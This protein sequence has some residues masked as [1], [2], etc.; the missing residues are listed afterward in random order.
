MPH[1]ETK[2]ADLAA[3][4][5]DLAQDLDGA[6]I[7]LQLKQPADASGSVV[8]IVRVRDTTGDLGST[9][10]CL[11]RCLR[12]P[13]KTDAG[14][15]TKQQQLSKSNCRQHQQAEESN[16]RGH[17]HAQRLDL[18]PRPHISC[19][20]GVQTGSRPDRVTIGNKC[21]EGKWPET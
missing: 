10:Q 20:V 12:W 4:E 7:I 16:L 18:Y 14:T 9:L 11:D 6:K 8:Q 15:L 3:E 17:C 1:G 19:R 21:C 13:L 5:L 2:A